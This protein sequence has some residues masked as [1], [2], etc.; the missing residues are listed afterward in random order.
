MTLGL[1]LMGAVLPGVQ[2]LG[3]RGPVNLEITPANQTLGVGATHQYAACTR[4]LGAVKKNICSRNVTNSAKW[5][6]SNPAVATVG[7]HGLVTAKVPGTAKILATSGPAHNAV[8]VTVLTAVCGDGIRQTGE[9]CDDGNTTNLDACSASCLFEDDLYVNSLTMQF[10]TG[11]G[12][13]SKNALGSAFPNGTVQQEIQNSISANVLNVGM[14]LTML[15]LQDPTGQ[16]SPQQFKLGVLQGSTPV[17]TCSGGSPPTV[18]STTDGWTSAF[19]AFLDANRVPLFKLDAHVQGR[20]RFGYPHRR[21]GRVRCALQSG[22]T[23]SQLSSG[24][25]HRSGQYL[26]QFASPSLRLHSR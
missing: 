12:S 13:C 8:P 6:S 1:A 25:R 20:I 17:G 22:G 7:A 15:G 10:G 18:T 3:Q 24:Q 21:P 2:A 16:V 4:F 14:L 5:L 23:A 19:T 11:S 9:Q 26:C